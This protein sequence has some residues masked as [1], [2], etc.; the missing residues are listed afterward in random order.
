MIRTAGASNAWMGGGAVMEGR[1]ERD[2]EFFQGLAPGNAV[3]YRFDTERGQVTG[4][5]MQL[6]CWIE[7]QWWPVARYDSAHGQP[8]LD[9]LDWAGA[10][11][12]KRWL[13]A[14]IGNKDAMRLARRDFV[15]HWP[16]YRE[17]FVR[18]KPQP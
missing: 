17:A 9:L 7:E 16:A 4:F 8:H 12:D 6:E 2:Q 14:G 10:V 15:D 3:R 5:T 13:P 11:V 1:V 18:R